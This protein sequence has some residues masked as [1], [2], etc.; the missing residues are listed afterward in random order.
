MSVA[1]VISGKIFAAP[2]RARRLSCRRL[3]RDPAAR[4][5]GAAV[6]ATQSPTRKA[7]AFM[8]GLAATPAGAAAGHKVDNTILL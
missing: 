1:A 2:R 8:R 3:C 5:I 7:S 4:S 6:S